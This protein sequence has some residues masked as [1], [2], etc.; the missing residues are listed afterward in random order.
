MIRKKQQ[1][2]LKEKQQHVSLVHVQIHV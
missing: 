1:E 2:C